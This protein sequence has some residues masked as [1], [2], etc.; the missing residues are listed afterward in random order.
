M[1][2]GTYI[3]EVIEQDGELFLPLDPKML[4]ELGWKEGDDIVWK[5][6][7]DTGVYII[8]KASVEIDNSNE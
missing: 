5:V 3:A 8:K 7:G 6:V 2:V 4:E 1:G